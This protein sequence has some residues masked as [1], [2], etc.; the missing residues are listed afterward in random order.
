MFLGREEELSELETRW[1]SGRFE[2]GIVYGARRIGKTSMLR[3]F[4]RGKHAF[5]FQARLEDETGNLAAFSREFHAFLGL[6]TN[7]TYLSFEDAFH[8]VA[9]HAQNQRMIFV[10]DE[11]AYLCGKSQALLSML[12]YYMDHSFREAG[13]MIIL[14][15]SNVS[16]MRE[17]MDDRNNPLYQRATFQIHLK[18]IEK[19]H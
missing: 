8:D 15:G 11:I 19:I 5:Y 1:Q 3:E 2:V 9:K 7:T 13:M 18:K 17:L 12:Q 16:F 14:S 10:I 4:S 6:E